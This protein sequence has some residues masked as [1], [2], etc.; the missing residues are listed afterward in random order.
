MTL[1]DIIATKTGSEVMLKLHDKS[2]T[3][4]M[5]GE[6]LSRDISPKFQNRTYEQYLNDF[7]QIRFIEV[8]TAKEAD[9]DFIPE[10]GYIAEEKLDGHR[11][12]CYMT[13]DGNRFFSRRISK[14]TD[15]Y[16]ENT[17]CV[18]HLRDYEHNFH[19][20]VLDGEITMPT[21][22]DVQSVLGALPETAVQ[23]MLEKGLATYN[24]FDILYYKGLK[25]ENFPLYK[26]KIF[27]N[28]IF[29][30]INTPH[31]LKVKSYAI[32]ATINAFPQLCLHEV[33]SFRQLLY[34]MWDNGLEGLIVKNLNAPYEQ[35]RTKN[36]LKLKPL[37]FRDVVI[38]GFQPAT[39]EY[40]G[41][42][43]HTWEYWENDLTDLRKDPIAVTKPHA[44]GWIGAIEFGVYKDGELIKV[45][46]A[47]G[48]SDQDLEYIKQNKNDLIGTVIEVKANDFSDKSIGSLRHPR[49]SR[50]RNIDKNPED[51][52]WEAYINA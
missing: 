2:L 45:G 24:V 5:T 40:T 43:P 51:C 8:Q 41:K 38:T 52:T 50:F 44:K 39:R 26:R 36:F 31:I 29:E 9:K 11:A 47:K 7:P 21:F 16:A 33:K 28:A 13:K 42:A 4:A 6:I 30:E 17:D 48:L 14:K 12:L 34:D 20:T 15:W 22:S 23:N 37:L 18:P 32:P 27:M 19:G 35:K 46:E 1:Y 25:V 3:D 49:F 10:D